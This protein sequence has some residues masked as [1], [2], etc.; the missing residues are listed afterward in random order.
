MAE[1][2]RPSW[3]K[4][5][6]EWTEKDEQLIKILALESVAKEGNLQAQVMAAMFHESDEII[7]KD[8]EKAYY[9]YDLAA[10]QNS[11]IGQFA[12]GRALMLGLG[13]SVNQKEAVVWLKKASEN[14]EFNADLL[15]GEC[16]SQGL[17]V[18]EDGKQAVKHYMK[19]AAHSVFEAEYRLWKCY[20]RGLGVPVNEE[21]AKKWMDR[22][23][24]NPNYYDLEKE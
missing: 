10:K 23:K 14:G 9:F 20:E 7:P 19:A 11:S 24:S 4:E 21:E 5:D 22:A 6:E 12:V 17:G 2:E 8:Y 1:L 16:Y 3:L 15:L 13:V 18:E